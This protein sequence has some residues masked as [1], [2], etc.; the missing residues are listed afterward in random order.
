MT[1]APLVARWVTQPFSI[2]SIRTGAV[3]DGMRPE[4]EDDG[5]IGIVGLADAFDGF[6]N[7]I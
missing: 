3:F 1:P 5:F 7:G 4:S 2:R 6:F